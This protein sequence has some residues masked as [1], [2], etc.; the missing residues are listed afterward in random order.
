MLPDWLSP[1]QIPDVIGPFRIV[2]LLG[3]GGAG[4][5]FLAER[6]EQFTQ[7]VAIKILHPQLFPDSTESGLHQEGQ[8]LAAL[9]HPGIVRLLDSG[10]TPEG[11]HYLVMEYVD[12]EP[13]D[14]YCDTLSLPIRRR[15][16]I[17]LEILDIVEYAH[18]RLII[19]SDLK[20]ANMM[21][22]EGGKVSLLDFGV[23][24]M[25]WKNQPGEER[26]RSYSRNFAS[27]EQL[28]GERLTVAS[29]VYSLGAIAHS[30]LTGLL[31]H[32]VTS[33]SLHSQPPGTST[34]Q[35]ATELAR[36]NP[37]LLKSVAECRKES[38]NQFLTAM[39][40]DL[41]AILNKALRI[42]PTERFES[43]Q[44]MA[45]DLRRHLAGYPLHIRPAGWATHA[46]KWILRNRALAGLALT[47]TLVVILS[48]VGITAQTAQAARKRQLAI[49]RL[50]EL[51]TLTDT[52]AGELY[53]SVHGLP[54][55]ESAQADLLQNAHAAM[56]KLAAE[57]FQD[58]QLDVEIAEEYEK[59]ARIEL[60]QAAKSPQADA[61]PLKI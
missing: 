3:E 56:Q 30:V 25:L 38:P 28:A 51:A 58:P 11:L 60:A 55:S 48:L 57:E 27:P 39:R 4:A 59:L 40:G 19:H 50:H 13:F 23:A 9:D 2:R 36:M 12:G 5:V 22:T 26:P 21:V 14:V 54:G 20:P 6:I 45:E 8:V 31:P 52:L 44:E 32:P 24:S 53:G 10:E 34:A 16:E 61:R 47:L 1:T 15:I 41:E 29:D 7:R 33:N 17:L 35:T 43:V 37:V 42:H 49:E 18:R 46:Q